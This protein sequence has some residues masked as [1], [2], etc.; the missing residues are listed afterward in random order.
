MSAPQELEACL[1]PDD[2]DD[3]RAK[4]WQ[5]SEELREFSS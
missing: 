3:L 4:G 2:V 5:I 1:T